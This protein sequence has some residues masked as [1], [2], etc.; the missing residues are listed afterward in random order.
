[1]FEVPKLFGVQGFTSEEAVYRFFFDDGV[2]IVVLGLTQDCRA[3]FDFAEI[4]GVGAGGDAF[5]D[6]LWNRPS[7]FYHFSAPFALISFLLILSIRLLTC[8]SFISIFPLCH[9]IFD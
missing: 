2:Q 6:L 3:A 8:K 5:Q 7:Q 4:F 1:M 9:L